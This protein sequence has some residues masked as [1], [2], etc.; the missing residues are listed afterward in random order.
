MAPEQARGTVELLGPQTDVYGL[1]A[2]FYQL[3]SGCPL[4]VGDSPDDIREAARLGNYT[5]LREHQPRIPRE[6]D[7]LCQEAL[8]AD[9][10]KRLASAGEFA[11]RLRAYVR[12][13]KLLVAGLLTLA[14]A[15]AIVLVL[16][17]VRPFQ[18]VDPPVVEANDKP[19]APAAILHN[20]AASQPAKEPVVQPAKPPPIVE[21]PP[22]GWQIYRSAAGG[23]S[24]WLPGTP[25][26]SESDV[27]GKR[28][29]IQMKQV[30]L[31]DV[32][33]G[34]QFHVSYADH[35][36]TLFPDADK[37][38]DAARDGALKK[39]GAELTKEERIQLGTHPGRELWFALPKAKGLVL[40][41][42]IYLVGQRNYQLLIGGAAH[43]VDGPAADTFFRSFRLDRAF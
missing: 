13:P 38:L 17:I 35:N 25:S 23:Y 21:Q 39:S 7:A 18:H 27:P 33:S 8:A 40:R 10:T 22:A 30:S 15:A 31:K 26:E 3:L 11:R 5:P 28:G 1:G 24:V 12:R 4:R 16:A 42:R 14:L 20:P 36:N 2:I 29:E 19:A 6:L 43:A 41:M 9:P 37:A 32:P 34:L